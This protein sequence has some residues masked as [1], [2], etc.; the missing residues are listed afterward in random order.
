[1]AE[2]QDFLTGAPVE[3]ESLAKQLVSGAPPLSQALLYAIQI[4]GILKTAHSRGLV[5]GALSVD[6]VVVTKAGVRLL[7]PAGADAADIVYRSPEQARGE[8]ADWRSDVFAFGALLRRLVPT[9]AE[10]PPLETLIESLM[11]DDPACRRQRI[12]NAVTELRLIRSLDARAPRARR[13]SGAQSVAARRGVV[14]GSMRRTRL[15][16]FAGFALFAVTASTL[17][18]VLL[19][20]N[21]PAAHSF[22]FTLTESDRTT[23]IGGLAVSPDGRSLAFSAIGQDGRRMLWLRSL[24]ALHGVVIPGTEDASEPFWSPDGESI[25][26]FA[27]NSLRKVRLTGDPPETICSAEAA[28]GG[29]TWSRY[30]IILFAPGL[31]NGLFRVPATGG[32]PDFVLN[33]DMARGE[34]SLLWPQFL[35]DGKHF[36]YFVRSDSA[37]TTGA[38]AGSLDGSEHRLLFRSQSNAIYAGMTHGDSAGRGYLLFMKEGSLMGQ[39]FNGARRSLEGDPVTLADD[40]DTLASLY[41]MPVSV[42]NNGVLA[43]QSVS[44]RTRQIAWIDRSGRQLGLVGGPADYGHPRL[45]PDGGRIAVERMEPAGKHSD[46]WILDSDGAATQVTNSRIG[47]K[48]F[49][50]WSPD[51]DRIVFSDDQDGVWNL[52]WERVGNDQSNREE[53]LFKSAFAKH[54]TDWSRDGDS[55][56]FTS[57]AQGGNSGLW[58][59]SPADGQAAPVADS[60]YSEESGALSPDGKWLAYQSDESGSAEIYVRPMSGKSQW[61]VSTDGGGMP[62]W[63]RDG[64]ELYYLTPG[65]YMLAVPVRAAG[66]VPKFGPAQVLFRTRQ[67]PKTWNFFDVSADGQTFLVNL[68]LEDSNSS[69]VTVV[70]DWTEKLKS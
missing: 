55:I 6:C 8:A 52:Y 5:H 36:V 22:K 51:G 44:R 49:P 17:A 48:A 32:S 69:P 19:V 35:P 41:L 1:M 47:S 58:K 28:A 61:R 11:Q 31:A 57:S 60:V 29:A 16:A 18:G 23:H 64:G 13:P 24:D 53:L 54:P 46:I 12:Q 45:S 15:F 21:R 34:R 30:G 66:G 26:F 50:V 20:D 27:S 59:L 56:V 39:A 4:G 68:P 40:L 10:L 7:K 70:T 38:Y 9:A 43:F 25:G 62:R 37:E 65:G 33:P 2:N 14:Q 42:S 63:R 67:L 3:G